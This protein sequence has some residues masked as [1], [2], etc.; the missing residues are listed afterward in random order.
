MI[1]LKTHQQFLIIFFTQIFTPKQKIVNSINS[2]NND[3]TVNIHQRLLLVQVGF[4][5]EPP[6]LGLV[7]YSDPRQ[8]PDQP[9][10][11]HNLNIRREINL[12]GLQVIRYR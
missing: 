11:P 7:K 10:I 2:S 8:N 5:L 4:G 12:I 9:Q 6:F 1:K 3:P